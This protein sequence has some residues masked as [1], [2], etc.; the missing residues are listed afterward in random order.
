MIISPH[1]ARNPS[2]RERR[3][4]EELEEKINRLLLQDRDSY[5]FYPPLGLNDT[6]REALVGQIKYADWMVEVSRGSDFETWIISS[7]F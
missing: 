2:E 4:V 7:R 1:A 6:V 5:I 3:Q